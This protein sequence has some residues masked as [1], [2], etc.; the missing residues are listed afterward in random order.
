MN[1]TCVEGLTTISIG[2]PPGAA[3]LSMR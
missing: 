2:E 1:R 3:E